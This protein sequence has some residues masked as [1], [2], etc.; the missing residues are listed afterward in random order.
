MCAAADLARIYLRSK[1]ARPRFI[2]RLVRSVFNLP[3]TVVSFFASCAA[4]A[5]AD[6]KTQAALHKAMAQL[7]EITRERDA[8][9]KGARRAARSPR[10]PS[11]S[12]AAAATCRPRAPP[13]ATPLSSQSS[14]A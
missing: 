9:V 5:M 8:M 6:V 7:D 14:R 4:S 1:P 12:G 2:S 3:P 10:A 11:E 13:S